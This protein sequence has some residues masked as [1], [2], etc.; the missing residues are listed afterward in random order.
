MLDEIFFFLVGIV[1]NRLPKRTV[2]SCLL[3]EKM[4]KISD[5]QETMYVLTLLLLLS[6]G[7]AQNILTG[8]EPGY[9]FS[10]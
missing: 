1:G 4:D 7:V 10:A 3:K 9:E 2:P 6:F 5:T 8:S